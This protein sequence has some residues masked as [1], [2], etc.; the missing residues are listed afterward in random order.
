[1]SDQPAASAAPVLEYG[2]GR[3]N[4]GVRRPRPPVLG[5]ATVGVLLFPLV[6]ALAYPI[7]RRFPDGWQVVTSVEVASP[8]WDEYGRPVRFEVSSMG[9]GLGD[10]A[11]LRRCEVNFRAYR[12]GLQLDV[13]LSDMSYHC[14]SPV[15]D[16]RGA[17]PLTREALLDCLADA[18][19][20]PGSAE[21]GRVA[22]ALLYEINE[23]R[24][25]RL[26]PNDPNIF[27]KRW[28][29]GYRLISLGYSGH[30]LWLPWYTPW[31]VPVWLVAS[32]YAARPA[33]RRY[34]RE[35]AGFEIAGSFARD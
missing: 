24:A 16:S 32:V 23:L 2:T 17:G 20:D 8:K 6:L 21:G 4:P 34:R 35:V 30:L 18:E 15:R 14:S 11:R 3:R 33:V 29:R 27:V 5:V 10:R 12:T 7:A 19:F 1:M 25:G 28:M 13:D 22:D 9:T 31:C 26:R